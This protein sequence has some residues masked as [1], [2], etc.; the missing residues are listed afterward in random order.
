MSASSSSKSLGTLYRRKGGKE[1]KADADNR[2]KEVREA[3]FYIR[4]TVNGKQKRQALRDEEGNRI[5]DL[6]SAENARLRLLR[7]LLIEDKAERLKQLQSI[8]RDTEEEALELQAE[9]GPQIPINE[10]WKKYLPVRKRMAGSDTLKQYKFQAD[11]FISWIEHNKPHIQT[12]EDLNSNAARAFESYLNESGKSPNTVYK[13]ISLLDLI[14]DRFQKRLKVA[15]GNPWKELLEDANDAKQPPKR[16][17]PFTE[18]ELEKIFSNAKGRMYILFMLGY[19]SGLRLGDICGLQWKEIELDNRR[20]VKE[21][22]KTKKRN[23]KPVMIPL[24]RDLY[25]ELIDIPESK[26]KG[27]VLPY[28]AKQYKKDPSGIT[29]ENKEFFESLGIDLYD[30]SNEGGKRKQSIKGMHSF[31]HNFVSLC[32]REGVP[33]PIVG[34]IIGH[35]NPLVSLIYYHNDQKA[36]IQAI[37]SLPSIKKRIGSAYTVEQE[38]PGLLSVF[39]GLLNGMDENNFEDIKNELLQMI[40]E[41]KQ[42]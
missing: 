29:K 5:Y 6:E 37:Q 1:F 26:R 4:Y 28:Y 22:R 24:H 36:T 25:T 9:E 17:E 33:A 21:P 41:A 19:Y 30:G 14:W 42:G 15:H 18:Q 8:L 7:P 35:S 3:P 39:E 31:R 12:T 20:I 40:Q 38:E 27:Y 23:P 32:Y 11:E 2:K 10:I 34:S 13:Y 16:K